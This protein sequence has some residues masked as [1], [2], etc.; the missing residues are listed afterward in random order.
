MKKMI[1]RVVLALSLIAALGAG[2]ASAANYEEALKLVR[3][4]KY[5]RAL[6]EFKIL[7]NDGHPQ[8]QFSVGLMYHL[9]RGVP[10]DAK[11]AYAWYK[12]AAVQ[13][14]PAALNNIGMMYLNGEYVAQNREVAFELFQM[15]SFEH[16]QAKDNLGQCYENA[17][18]V[19]RNIEKAIDFYRLAGEQDY[20]LG[21][22]HAGQLFEKGYP[23]T[24]KDETQAVKWYTLAAEKDY[25]KA[26]TRLIELKRLP[27]HLKK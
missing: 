2:A 22:Y 7:A 19:A 26:I 10:P 20:T 8:S 16:P 18:G 6:S 11:I 5:D 27:D 17:W 21:Y 23:G 24:P 15:S 9:G 4:G 13:E 1:A 3:T 12:K 25:T 14:H